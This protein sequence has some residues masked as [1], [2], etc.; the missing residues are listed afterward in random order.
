MVTICDM[1]ITIDSLY[2]I[3]LCLRSRVRLVGPAAVACLKLCVLKN[4]RELI[5]R[6]LEFSAFTWFTIAQ[7]GHLILNDLIN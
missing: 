4:T 2:I 6:I 5:T 7:N 3:C 1:H